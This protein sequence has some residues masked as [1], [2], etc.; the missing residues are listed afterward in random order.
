M[1]EIIQS[2]PQGG[3]E[4]VMKAMLFL[5]IDR[6]TENKKYDPNYRYTQGGKID[7]SFY[8][9]AKHFYVHMWE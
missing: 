7:S 4:G 8:A 2:P 6:L 1:F 3:K 9:A 5:A